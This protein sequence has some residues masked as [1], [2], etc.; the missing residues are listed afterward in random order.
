VFAALCPFSF[1]QQ[2]VIVLRLAQEGIM[3]GYVIATKTST[4]NPTL[5]EAIRQLRA[6][7]VVVA[8]ACQ[9]NDDPQDGSPYHMDLHMIPS[10]RVIR[11]SQNLGALSSGCRLDPTALEEAVG[12]VEA[13][14][15]G[16]ELLLANK[17]GKQE[18]EGRGFRP[19]IGAALAAGIPVL[20]AVRD[21]TVPAFQAFTEGMGEELPNDP[22]AVLEWARR[23]VAELA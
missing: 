12:L 2:A 11:I 14:L 18:A 5:T 7:G 22:A 8:G 23:T 21:E 15:D 20:L 16:A 19:V 4:A 3:L 17:F 10:G 13:S 9:V 1:A 6:E